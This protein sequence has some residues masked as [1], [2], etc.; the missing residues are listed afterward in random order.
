[1]GPKKAKLAA[2]E[3][4]YSDATALVAAKKEELAIV[5]ATVEDLVAQLQDAKNKMN[6]LQKKRD[7]C[8]NKLV[9]AEKLITGLGGEKVSWTNKAKKLGID[10][11]NLTGDIL[12]AA[13]I[14]AYLGVFTAQYR[15]E[16][17]TAWLTKLVALQATQ[18]KQ[19]NNERPE[20]DHSASVVLHLCVG[21]GS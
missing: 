15:N 4:A 1:M 3:Q 13:G 9:R 20:R 12:I 5:I 7:D 19:H 16:A 8:A 21:A 6:D 14:L 11:V 18:G 10:Y 2:A 17:T